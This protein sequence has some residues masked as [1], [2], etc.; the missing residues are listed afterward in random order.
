MP[1]APDRRLKPIRNNADLDRALIR[2]G[3]L[4]DARPAAG[5]AEADEADILLV[6]IETYRA[7]QL[8]QLASGN[9]VTAIRLVMAEQRRSQADLAALLGSSARASEILGGKRRPSLAAIRRLYRAWSIPADLLI[10]E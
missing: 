7:V 3:A 9:V 2:L 1:P 6:L 8:R 5:S 4:E 10:G